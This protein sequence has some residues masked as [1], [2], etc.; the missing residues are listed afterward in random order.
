LNF[1]KQYIFK[2]LF[3]AT[4]FFVSVNNVFYSYEKNSNEVIAL[5]EEET[6]LNSSNFLKS[7][8]YHQNKLRDINNFF[9]NYKPHS[10]NIN[11]NYLAY[12]LGLFKVENQQLDLCS[13]NKVI[14]TLN[15]QKV[16]IN[17]ICRY[18]I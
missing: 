16:S 2:L 17:T 4:L 15:L 6:E 5:E 1:K 8:L 13:L 10:E 14:R 12:L 11:S 3:V 9:N 7:P 18:N